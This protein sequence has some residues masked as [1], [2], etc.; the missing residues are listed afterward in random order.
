MFLPD[1]LD[2]KT[3]E[4]EPT[5]TRVRAERTDVPLRYAAMRE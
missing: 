3:A 1:W 5:H 4:S 2:T